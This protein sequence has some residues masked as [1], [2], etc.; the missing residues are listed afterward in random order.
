MTPGFFVSITVRMWLPFTEMCK[1]GKGYVLERKS[2]DSI[3]D[4]LN[5]K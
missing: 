4:M 5:L 2:K 1:F 3:L